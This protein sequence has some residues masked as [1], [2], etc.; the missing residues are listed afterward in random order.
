MLHSW[1]NELLFK[2]RSRLQF[3]RAHYQ[4]QG[5]LIALSPVEES[6]LVTYHF[7][8]FALELSPLQFKRNLATLW[9]V[10]QFKTWSE[11]SA[12]EFKFILEVGCQ[13]FSRLPALKSFLKNKKMQNHLTGIEV[14]PFPILSDFHSR[15]DRAQYYMSLVDEASYVAAD[16]FAYNKTAHGV[17]CFFPFVS[18]APALRWG[19]PARFANA[20]LWVKSFLRCIRP[21]GFVLVVHQ[22]PEEQQIF[23]EARKSSTNELC[24]VERHVLSCPFLPP[25]IPSYVSLYR[26][27]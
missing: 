16:F 15:W 11:F 14:D 20:D 9:L 12:L 2:L 1:S 13:D 3:R 19:L 25:K 22:G 23:D 5:R 21:G 26:R 27:M 10:E 4:E 7:A 6:L 18:T 24:L 8:K 17:F